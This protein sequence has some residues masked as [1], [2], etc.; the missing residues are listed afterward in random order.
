MPLGRSRG[1][2]RRQ[3][4]GLST[5]WVEAQ[6]LGKGK[7]NYGVFVEGTARYLGE[8]SRRNCQ[9]LVFCKHRGLT[10]PQGGYVRPWVTGYNM[11]LETTRFTKALNSVQEGPKA[12]S[13]KSNPS[14]GQEGST[15]GA[16]A[17]GCSIRS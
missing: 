5:E 6:L 15:L 2:R 10:G 12:R 9:T 17:L 13:Q 3:I 14:G 7:S 11:E 8:M 4:W 16:V 1:S